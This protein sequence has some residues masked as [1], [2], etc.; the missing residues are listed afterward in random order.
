MQQPPF[1]NQLHN[2]HLENNISL[3][4]MSQICFGKTPNPSMC[5]NQASLATLN[6]P[7]LIKLLNNP[8]LLS[9]INN[10]ALQ[11][12]LQ[13]QLNQLNQPN[14]NQNQPKQSNPVITPPT[15]IVEK[16]IPAPASSKFD[17]TFAPF[18]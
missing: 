11:V 7:N 6:N 18:L 9:I 1:N 17:S 2:I 14:L 10:P 8:N 15:K 3:N 13:N 5:L 4:P 12:L 16:F